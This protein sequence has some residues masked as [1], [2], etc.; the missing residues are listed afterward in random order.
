MFQ[1]IHCPALE[2]QS[3]STIIA[4]SWMDLAKLYPIHNS[5]HLYTYTGITIGFTS[6]EY[7]TPNEMGSF[8][9]VCATITDGEVDRDVSF[10]INLV[11]GGSATRKLGN[12]CSV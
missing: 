6:T 2:V 7:T 5:M 1:L 9:D 3:A 8:S 12:M 4:V 11:S 10:N